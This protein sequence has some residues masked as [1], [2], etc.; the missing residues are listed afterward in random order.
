MYSRSISTGSPSLSSYIICAYINSTFCMCIHTQFVCVYKESVR[1]ELEEGMRRGGQATTLSSP[2]YCL[3]I[4]S[5]LCV[6]VYVGG[7]TLGWRRKRRARAQRGCSASSMYITLP[8]PT[9]AAHTYSLYVY[10]YAYAQSKVCACNP[11]PRLSS[12]SKQES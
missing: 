3:C 2:I 6:Y 1:A 10:I 9:E 12:F 7:S 4:D 8:P 5:I 11:L